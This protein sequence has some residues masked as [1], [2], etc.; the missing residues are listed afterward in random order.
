MKTHDILPELLNEAKS[1]LDTY[2]KEKAAAN[3]AKA[4]ANRA[5][6][7]ANRLA[8]HDALAARLKPLAAK[9]QPGKMDSIDFRGKEI[10]DIINKNDKQ[11]A[12]ALC[13][14]FKIK[15]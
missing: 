2:A 9:T 1:R 13:K 7:R 10:Q 15:Y 11:A 3:R 6:A 5:E 4:A 14:E 12:K 8:A